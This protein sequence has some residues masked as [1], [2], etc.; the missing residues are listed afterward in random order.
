MSLQIPPGPFAAYLFDCDGTLA[1]TMPLHYRAWSHAFSKHGG[2]FSYTW[3]YF[4]SLA[5]IGM[6]DTVHLLNERHELSMDADQVVAAQMAYID[7]HH[8]EVEPIEPV[9]TFAREVAQT[10]PVAVVS[11]GNRPHVH[12][13]LRVVG[14]G[15]LFPVVITQEDIS[16][17]KPAPDGYLLAA[18]RLGVAPGKCLVFED[19]QLGLQAA[20]AAGMQSVYIEPARYSKGAG[21]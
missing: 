17:G 8:A 11:G 15:A 18:E 19:S 7:A 1:D 21:I 9:V 16:R 5:G 14:V 3:D 13:S 12:T 2:D 6:H 20:A 4:Y 10:A